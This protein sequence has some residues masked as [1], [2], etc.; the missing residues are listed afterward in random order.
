MALYAHDVLVYLSNPD[1]SL[2][3][4]FDFLEEY[5]RFSGYK[6]NTKKTQMLSFGF[7]PIK[8][9]RQRLNINWNQKAIKYLGVWLTQDLTK[10]Y[11]KNYNIINGKIKEDLKRWSSL[12][13]LDFSS[14]IESIKMNVLP[15]L[16]YLFQS[17][18]VEIPPE[19]FQ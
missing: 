13:H 3:K 18:P 2:P 16:L 4:L 5:G 10:L 8:E 19:Q 7:N 1:I 11:K 15:R 9:L 6:L 17:L 14:R 12:P